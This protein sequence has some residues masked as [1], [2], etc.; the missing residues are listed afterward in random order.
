MENLIVA[1]T[2]Q[3]REIVRQELENFHQ[4]NPVQVAPQ[5]VSKVVFDLTQLCEHYKFC[6]QTIYKK[7]AKRLI[8]H[9]KQGKK[10]FFEKSEIDAWLLENKV[11]SPS[12]IEHK[13]DQFTLKNP[14]RRK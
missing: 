8:P 1:T 6:R 12:K 11:G 13:A 4:S 7:A 5:A 9:S 2:D 3:L 10:L 14:R